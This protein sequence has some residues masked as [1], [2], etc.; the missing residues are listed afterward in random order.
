MLEQRLG[1]GVGH[2]R[3]VSEVDAVALAKRLFLR[4]AE[5]HEPGHIRFYHQPSSGGTERGRR[6]A[7]CNRATDARNRHGLF[8]GARFGGRSRRGPFRGRHGGRRRRG[9]ST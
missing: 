1:D 9:A 2:E 5:R 3:E 6:H 4:V 8:V 7:L